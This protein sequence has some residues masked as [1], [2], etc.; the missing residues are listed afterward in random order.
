LLGKKPFPG[1]LNI[2][3]DKP[4]ILRQVVP[5]DAKPKQFGVKASI[6][7]VPCIVYRW[8]G[9]PLHVLEVIADV[10]LRKSLGLEDEQEV[11]L[12]LPDNSLREPSGW[13]I[14]LWKMFY[15]KKPELYYDTEA[16]KSLMRFKIF[17]KMICQRRF[18]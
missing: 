3:L 12:T 18:N 8:R 15:G 10:S 9:A 2:V 4:F 14:W 1:T 7:G 11:N 13:K 6:N 16:M 5:L 17:H